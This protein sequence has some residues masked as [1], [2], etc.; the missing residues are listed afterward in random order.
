MKYSCLSDCTGPYVYLSTC[1]VTQVEASRKLLNEMKDLGLKPNNGTYRGIFKSLVK[2]GD[3][4]K[5]IQ[6]IQEEMVKDGVTADQLNF[7]DAM[8]V[9]SKKN[10]GASLRI[11]EEMKK[12]PKPDLRHYLGPMIDADEFAERE[13]HEALVAEVESLD[14]LALTG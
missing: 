9:F 5:C 7:I 6:V 4:E 13:V 14:R 11:M 12:A 10:P 2:D 1:R 8:E 3:Y